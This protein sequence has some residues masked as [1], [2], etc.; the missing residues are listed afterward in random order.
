MATLDDLVRELGLLRARAARGTRSA[1]VSLDELASRVHE[2]KSTI[3]SYLTGRRLP[4]AQLL[5]RIVIALGSTP[6]ELHEWAEAWY[7]VGAVRDAARRGLADN[8]ARRSVAHQ[9][10]LPVDGFIGRTDQLAEL[11]QALACSR[12]AR[13]AVISGTAGVGKTALAVRW[14]HD[15][16][17]RFPA[18]QLYLDLRGFD[19]A[20]P[21]QPEQALVRLLHALGGP[22]PDIPVEVDELAAN[23]RSQLSGRRVLI[24]L[25]NARD[26]EQVRPLLPGT[27]S[28][29]VLVTSRD[30]M[31][32]LVA[33]HGG[34]RIDLPLL[35]MA[36]ATE[37]LR[38]LIGDRAAATSTH[39]PSASPAEVGP[40]QQV[41]PEAGTEQ[42]ALR[43]LADRCARLPLALRIA[44]ELAT[45]RPGT[46]IGD[47]A[48][49]LSA[50][51]HQ[52]DLLEAGDDARSALRTVFSWSYRRLPPQVAAAFRLISVHSGV[53][54]SP[55]AMAALMDSPILRAQRA[56]DTL[57]RAHLVQETSPGRY[58]LH[59]LLRSYSD[60]LAI[61]TDADADRRAALTRLVDHYLSTAVDAIDLLSPETASVGSDP[62]RNR[63]RTRRFTDPAVAGAWLDAEYVNLASAVQQ[64]ADGD[65]DQQVGEQAEI[66]VRHLEGGAQ[67]PAPR[68]V[69]RN[70][71][72]GA[73]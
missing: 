46:S 29:A 37:L 33:R 2:P 9:L 54:L 30:S 10:P 39:P 28:C 36:D 12:P 8:Q 31:A 4:P 15:S 23:Y 3:H 42:S 72:A 20:E 55:A 14:S 34:H 25:D 68:R 60:E 67:L 16:A 18:G 13:I 50:G 48:E 6:A 58:G 27:S 63:S 26:A 73:R 19:L 32:G 53:D 45:S 43:A 64:S 44:A 51:G 71:S 70:V 7:R 62:Q 38:E 65:V 66:V 22:I 57:A 24:V 47:L 49:E 35:P 11:D 1:R 17:D 59:S 5:D 40:A 52:L 61:A 41:R 69:T 21:M 56:I